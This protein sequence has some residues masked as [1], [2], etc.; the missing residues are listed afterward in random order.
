MC[1]IPLFLD[2]RMGYCFLQTIGGRCTAR[3]SDL[4]TV[5]KADCCCTMGAAWG[6]HCEICPT[7]DS[8]NYNELCLDKGFSVNGQGTCEH[9]FLFL[10][11]IIITD[12]SSKF[13]FSD[14][15]EC[16]TIPDLC[17]NGL[18]IN[19]LGSYRCVCN[20]GYKADKTG[21]QC[22]GK[23]STN[24][25]HREKNIISNEIYIF[26]SNFRYKRVRVNTKAVQVQLSE[27][28]RKFHLFLSG[29]FHFEP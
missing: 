8:D 10:I 16:R 19:T 5:T 20:K 6:P 18:C 25:V 13:S 4:K 28:G 1:C 29:R 12:S 24:L 2:R 17:K 26:I 23:Y 21:T 22:V 7:K 14:I 27:H 11:M 15:D 3:T 9:F